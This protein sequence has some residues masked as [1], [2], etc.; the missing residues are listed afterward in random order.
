M[1]RGY[2]EDYRIVRGY[3]GY[4]EDIQRIFREYFREDL[5]NI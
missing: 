5:E 2:L 1:F 3:R 4:L